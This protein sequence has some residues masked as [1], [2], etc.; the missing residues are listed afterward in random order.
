MDTTLILPSSVKKT[1][2]ANG[3]IFYV[4][5][6]KKEPGNWRPAINIKLGIRAESFPHRPKFGN[7][8]IIF[9]KKIHPNSALFADAIAQIDRVYGRKRRGDDFYTTIVSSGISGSYKI[10]RR[11]YFDITHRRTIYVFYWDKTSIVSLTGEDFPFFEN[12]KAYQDFS[13][14]EMS[15]FMIWDSDTGDLYGAIDMGMYRRDRKDDKGYISSDIEAA[16]NLFL[17]WRASSC[18]DYSD[19]KEMFNKA[20]EDIRKKLEHGKDSG[21]NKSIAICISKDGTVLENNVKD[22][23]KASRKLVV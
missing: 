22:A 21:V 11:E 14:H 3:F 19:Y 2:E 8:K 15:T 1:Y 4:E 20:G 16:A 7:S 5:V 9:A 17:P 18:P 23:V 10:V 6:K 13:I 12:D